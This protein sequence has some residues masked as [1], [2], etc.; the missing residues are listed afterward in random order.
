MV[1]F[2]RCTLSMILLQPGL[3]MK[4]SMVLAVPGAQHSHRR[5]NKHEGGYLKGN[6]FKYEYEVYFMKQCLKKFPL[7]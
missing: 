5:I 4:R 6:H 2:P 1:L 3:P 7:L